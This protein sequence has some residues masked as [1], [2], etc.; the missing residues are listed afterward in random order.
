VVVV[1]LLLSVAALSLGVLITG[2]DGRHTAPVT[3]PASPAG[4]GGAPTAR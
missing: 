2:S 3:S 4:Q 1:L